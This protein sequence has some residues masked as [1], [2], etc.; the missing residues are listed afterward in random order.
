MHDR[1]SPA[2]SLRETLTAAV[3]EPAQG[4]PR[5]P[6]AFVLAPS[7]LVVPMRGLFR[8]AGVAAGIDE[9]LPPESAEHLLDELTAHLASR[10]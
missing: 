3:R 7:D 10:P 8:K 9:V 5:Q 4:A 1:V 2:D 6:P